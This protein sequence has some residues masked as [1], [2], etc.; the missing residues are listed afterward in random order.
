M[1][2]RTVLVYL[3]ILPY[4][5]VSCAMTSGILEYG[6]VTAGYYVEGRKA[7]SKGDSKK[8]L[9]YYKKSLDSAKGSDLGYV[10]PEYLPAGYTGGSVSKARLEY[11]VI[12]DAYQRVYNTDGRVR[13]ADETSTIKRAEK[14][15]PSANSQSEF[16]LKG[17]IKGENGKPVSL[18]P[19]FFETYWTT[20]NRSANTNHQ[21]EFSI[22]IKESG[23]LHI[24]ANKPHPIYENITSKIIFIKDKRVLEIDGKVYKPNDE[25]SIV[26]PYNAMGR[27]MKP[28]F[29]SIIACNAQ[30][31]SECVVNEGEDYIQKYHNV[32][33]SRWEE[34]Q[35]LVKENEPKL[36]RIKMEE[37]FNK[38]VKLDKNANYDAIISEGKK[39][40]NTYQNTEGS[41]WKE[42][43]KYINDAYAVKK[44]E[45]REKE[46][47]N[48]MSLNKDTDYE[49]II[50]GGKEYVEKYSNTGGSKWEEVESY[51]NEAHTTKMK[52][53]FLGIKNL[54]I[55]KDYE[56]IIVQ[57]KD[58]IGKYRNV[59]D[60]QWAEIEKLVKEAEVVKRDKEF[61]AIKN[62]SIKEDYESI[63]SQGKEYIEKYRNMAGSQWKEMANLVNKSK[64]RKKQVEEETRKAEEA[65]RKREERERL[66]EEKKAKERKGFEATNDPD[67]MIMVTKREYGRL[68]D[69]RGTYSLFPS[70]VFKI[71]N[72]GTDNKTLKQIKVRYEFAGQ[73]L[74]VD[75]IP[76]KGNI[77]PGIA[78]TISSVSKYG[79]NER[80]V[81]YDD[82]WSGATLV[83]IFWDDQKLG[84]LRVEYYNYKR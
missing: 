81:A 61:L 7:E 12:Y 69:D 76:F 57:G 33:D 70:I 40:I 59:K 18:T 30:G 14:A 72:T 27:M 73:I 71:K 2:D 42:V 36:A 17:H 23:T 56:T 79:L 16:E 4:I 11:S 68:E 49:A 8:A 48:I 77:P 24:D 65:E 1:K 67:I 35:R 20:E 10:P 39:Y 62:L 58:Y 34:I 29:E 63:I 50:S 53:E 25:V 74:Y 83:T 52:K 38:I 26:I 84:E 22:S 15:S 82:Y 5:C 21:G 31:A 78:K 47:Q 64:Q 54:N 43:E 41:K 60:S 32:V 28:S 6:S 3:L 66:K 19:I 44:D 75:K 45:E 80:A 46:F 13:G 55:K 37:E 51:V 9:E